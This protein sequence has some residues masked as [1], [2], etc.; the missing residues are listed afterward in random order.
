VVEERVAAVATAAEPEV[1][2]EK[3]TEGEPAAPG[4]PAGKEKAAAPKEKEAKK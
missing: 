2:T 1:I 3:K 4:A